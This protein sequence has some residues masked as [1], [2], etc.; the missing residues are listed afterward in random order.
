MPYPPDYGGVIDVFF[1][2]K[3]LHQAGVKIH[4]HCFEYGRGRHDELNQY[5]EH[6]NYYQRETLSAGIPLRLPYIVSSRINPELLKNISKDNYPILLEGIHCTWYLY[7]GEL[8]NRSVLLRLH[9]VEYEYYRQLA[10]STRNFYKKIYFLLESI[11]L[12]KYENRVARKTKLLVL[13]EK[14]KHT[15]QR[16]FSAKDVEFLPAFLPVKEVE[17]RTGKGDYCL[18]HG[19]LSVPENE[20]A[21][22]WLLKNVFNQLNVPFI[23]AGKKPTA[24][25]IKEI[26]KNNNV[27]LFENPSDGTMEE[28]IKNA[29]V[30]PLPSFNTTGIKIKLLIALF[31]GRFVVTNAA[32]LEGTRLEPLC[33]KAETPSAYKDKIE[34]LFKTSF[35]ENDIIKRKDILNSLYDSEKNAHQLIK[36][37]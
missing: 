20:K 14:D 18:Y 7:H 2:I 26:D 6:V 12:K 25:L 10:K 36:W 29:H 16:M 13:N 9:N 23:I 5:C 32:S 1:K 4:L 19:N 11:L 8:G 22:L 24:S 30:H 31:K 34:K 33:D 37:L 28:L 17:S 35:T 3:A 27:Q 15:Y 21:V